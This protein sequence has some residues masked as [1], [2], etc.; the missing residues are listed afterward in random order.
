M[1][2]RWSFRLACR[3]LRSTKLRA[4]IEKYLWQFDITMLSKHIISDGLILPNKI[5]L[6][7]KCWS[8]IYWNL[9]KKKKLYRYFEKHCSWIF[10]YFVV[11]VQPLSCVQLFATP[12]TA[13][14]RASLSFTVSW[15]LLKL[16]STE[17]VIISNHLILCCPLL[18]LPL[19]FPRIRVF[20]N[21]SALASGGQSIGASASTSVLPINI[22]G[23]FPLGLTG[24]I[25]L[26]SKGL[27]RVF[28]NTTIWG[29]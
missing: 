2:V 25:S 15:S 20:S 4:S 16:M 18:L 23:W 14:C 3:R 7:Y 27:S 9:K 29:L 6:S 19:I 24:L 28:S 22:Q 26:V 8:I 1:L 12:W 13:A 17:S 10:S 11:V 21:Q 5:P